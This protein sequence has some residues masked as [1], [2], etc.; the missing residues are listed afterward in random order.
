[1]NYQRLILDAIERPSEAFQ[2]AL[3][4]DDLAAL[5]LV[6]ILIRRAEPEELT[7]QGEA[8][9]SRL[10]PSAPLVELLSSC[11][12]LWKFPSSGSGDR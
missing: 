4:L 6:S 10:G 2:T 3:N 9:A 5:A 11:Q 7:K 12:I 1:M 8:L